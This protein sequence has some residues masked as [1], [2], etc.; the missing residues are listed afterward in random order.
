VYLECLFEI[1]FICVYIVA[2]VFVIVDY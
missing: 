1:L 2:A